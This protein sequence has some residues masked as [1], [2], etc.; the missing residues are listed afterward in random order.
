MFCYRKHFEQVKRCHSY[1]GFLFSKVHAVW[2]KCLKGCIQTGWSRCLGL[3]LKWLYLKQI[4]KTVYERYSILYSVSNGLCMVGYLKLLIGDTV[5]PF[6]ELVFDVSKWMS[7]S[8]WGLGRGLWEAI[9]K[10][11]ENMKVIMFYMFLS[12]LG[13]P[14]F[15][16]IPFISQF[17]GIFGSI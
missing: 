5:L 13:D 9:W 8:G 12:Y 3:S 15:K 11:W 17:L 4:S 2:P 16:T 6:V 10:V 7:W 14:Y 1:L